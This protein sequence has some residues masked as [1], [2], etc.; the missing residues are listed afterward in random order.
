MLMEIKVKN[1]QKYNA[2]RS[3]IKS[4]SWF[5]FEHSF[6]DMPESSEM[7]DRL[8]VIWLLILSGC[9]KKM[10]DRSVI[11]TEQI[12]RYRGYDQEYVLSAIEYFRKLGWIQI[13][14]HKISTPAETAQHKDSVDSIPRN[15]TERNVTRHN[16]NVTELSLVEQSGDHSRECE[17]GNGVR[18]VK[19]SDWDMFVAKTMQETIQEVNPDARKANKANLEK[20]ANQFRLMRTADK[21]D[22]EKIEKVLTWIFSPDCFWRTVVQSPANLRKN[23][24]QISSKFNN[25]KAKEMTLDELSTKAAEGAARPSDPD[26]IVF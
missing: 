22:T 9:C 10:S 2:A 18:K 14:Q 5:R 23:W 11:S 12:W 15:V 24:D 26:E 6:F 3:E 1:W 21:I 4:T 19:F 25:R 8:I 7:S 16:V 13:M 17:G 20:W